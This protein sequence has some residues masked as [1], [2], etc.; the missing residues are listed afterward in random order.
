MK[1]KVETLMNTSIYVTARVQKWNILRL[2]S[3][4]K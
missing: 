4:Q 2:K 1:S 3:Q